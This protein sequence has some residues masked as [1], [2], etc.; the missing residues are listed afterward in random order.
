MS[1]RNPNLII[2]GVNKAGTTSVFTYLTRHPEICGSNV[3]ETCYFLPL[4]Y[5]EPLG[6]LSE[7]RRHFEHCGHVRYLLEATPGY[8]YGGADLAERIADT[9]GEVRVLLLFREPVDRL[10]S[11]FAF[12]KSMLALES[13]LT[14]ET[15]VDRCMML[16]Q[17]AHDRRENN[18]YFGVEGGFYDRDFPAWSQIFGSRLRIA[19]FE[20]LR[21]D[22]RALLRDLCAWLDLDPAPFET[23]VLDIEN[24]TVGYRNPTLQR[25]ALMINRR[26][27]QIWRRAPAVKRLLKHGYRAVNA[28]AASAPPEYEPELLERLQALYL[29]HNRI[30]ATQLQTHGAESLPAWLKQ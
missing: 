1:D 10:R 29:P 6:P 8:Y 20:D 25:L 18:P 14:L 24:R 4:R 16:P 17:R 23:E 22:R 5:G 3:K 12:Q 19:F 13:D 28:P 30:F 7:Y 27:E 21:R 26:G 15:Y 9:L 2:A 11:F